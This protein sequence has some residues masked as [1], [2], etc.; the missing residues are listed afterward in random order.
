MHETIEGRAIL[1]G[2]GLT[3]RYDAQTVSQGLDVAIPAGQ[4][5]IIVGPNASGKSTLLRALSRLLKPSAGR[6]LLHDR[7]IRSW[8]AR[9]LARTM[10]LLPQSSI[11][12]AGITVADLVARGRYPHQSLLRQWSREDESA[13]RTALAE[14]R[15]ADLANR[16]VDTLSGG[17]RQ[18]VWLAMTLVQEAP[19]MLL[20][21]PTTYLDVA[22][23]LELLDLCRRLNHKKGRTLVMVLHDLNL[24]ARYADHMIAMKAGA[25]IAAGPPATVLT[26]DR[27]AAVFGIASVVMPDPFT[28]TPMVVPASAQDGA[29]R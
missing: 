15:V 29:A 25:I 14:T 5:T 21:E 4:V 26:P 22:H 9:E 12:P 2:E 3:L 6:V 11:A 18:R 24:A 10:A 13:V 7:D 19:L 17:Q 1:R 23:Q 20:D 27:V 28:G 8:G 16:P